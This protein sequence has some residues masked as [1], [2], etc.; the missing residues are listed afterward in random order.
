MK[1]IIQQITAELV[2]KMAQ[3]LFLW[4]RNLRTVTMFAPIFLE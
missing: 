2:E 1:I 3:S 4:D